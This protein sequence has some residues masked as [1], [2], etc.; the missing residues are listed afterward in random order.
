M[1]ECVLVFTPEGIAVGIYSDAV[2]WEA[3]GA[4]VAMLRASHVEFDV[5]RQRWAARDAHTGEEIASGA[6][7]ETVLASEHAHYV[8]LLQ[9]GAQPWTG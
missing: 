6:R 8:R 5:A 7:R 4:I 2:P 1:E 3:L 9:A